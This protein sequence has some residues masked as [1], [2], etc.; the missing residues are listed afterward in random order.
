M[1]LFVT[2]P[3]FGGFSS[4]KSNIITVLRL[5]AI[6]CCFE[7]IFISYT[8][9]NSKILEVYPATK[10]IVSTIWRRLQLSQYLKS[11]S[12]IDM[13]TFCKLFEGTSPS[14]DCVLTVTIARVHL[15]IKVTLFYLK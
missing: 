14:S 1:Q 12:A 13:F 2:V 9:H 11:L 8:C 4:Y 7:D 10:I 3:S 15:T 5:V 6:R